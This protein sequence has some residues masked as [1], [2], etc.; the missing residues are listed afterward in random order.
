MLRRSLPWGVLGVYLCVFVVL[1]ALHHHG[2]STDQTGTACCDHCHDSED[3]DPSPSGHDDDCSI[4]RVLHQSVSVTAPGE[5]PVSMDFVQPEPMSPAT[6]FLSSFSPG[7]A[8]PR[9]PPA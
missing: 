5:A 4:C 8:G 1:P 2:V 7:L 6:V 9:A 3:G